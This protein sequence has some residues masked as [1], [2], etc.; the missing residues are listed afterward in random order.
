[1]PAGFQLKSLKDLGF[2]EDIIED[3]DTFDGNALLKAIKIWETYQTPCFADDSGLEVF[4]LNMEPGVY[5][6]RYAGP[7]KDDKKNNAK[8]L[9]ELDGE[10]DRRAQFKTVL[11]LILNKEEKHYF[12]GIIEGT[13]REKKRGENGFGYDPLFVPNGSSKTFAEMSI[14]EKNEFSHRA[15]ALQKMLDFLDIYN[16]K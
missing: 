11:C 7:E 4:A 13:I 16:T 8:L 9:V 5:S 15:R 3:A 1:M 2:E 10:I 6:A 14:E 12:E